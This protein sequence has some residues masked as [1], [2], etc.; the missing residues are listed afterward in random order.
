MACCGFY[1]Y[2]TSKQELARRRAW[3]AH[4]VAKGCSAEKAR[5]CAGRKHRTWP[6]K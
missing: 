6:P 4:Y 5:T 3:V 2:R 1:E